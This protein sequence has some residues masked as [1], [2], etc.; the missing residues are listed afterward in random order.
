M[1]SFAIRSILGVVM[2]EKTNEKRNEITR[3]KFRIGINQ[4][5]TPK[6]V[7]TMTDFS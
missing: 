4:N 7:P 5:N 6:T 2:L 3:M 1:P